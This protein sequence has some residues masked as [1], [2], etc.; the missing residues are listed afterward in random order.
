MAG[1][2][3]ALPGAPC[4][5]LLFDMNDERLHTLAQ[6]HAYLDGTMGVDFA[7]AADERRDF[8]GALGRT[9][10]RFSYGAIC[11][12]PSFLQR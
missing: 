4:N 5:E 8:I 1:E 11:P 3:P 6:L 2:A 7:V 10:I 12:A 9:G